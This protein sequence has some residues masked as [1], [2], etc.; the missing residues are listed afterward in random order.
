[1]ATIPN[2]KYGQSRR[3]AEAEQASQNRWTISDWHDSVAHVRFN[4]P[5]VKEP[6]LI[7][8]LFPVGFPIYPPRAY[9]PFPIFHPNV[10]MKHKYLFIDILYERWSPRTTITQI[11]E[12]LYK[13][14]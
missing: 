13:I 7:I 14:L 2:P 1:M 11:C 10:S 12:Y 9:M 6:I 4:S 3:V 8:L 5:V